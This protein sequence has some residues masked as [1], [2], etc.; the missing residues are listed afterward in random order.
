MHELR[1]TNRQIERELQSDLKHL[2]SKAVKLID[3]WIETRSRIE[4]TELRLRRMCSYVLPDGPT[5]RGHLR[6]IGCILAAS[7]LL[8]SGCKFAKGI[9]SEG[10][11][12]QPHATA[13]PHR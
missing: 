5:N 9:V 4:V 3:E 8:I 12:V 6:D 13:T 1:K 10:N 7:L 11:S 2:R